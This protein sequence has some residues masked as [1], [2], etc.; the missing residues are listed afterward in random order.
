MFAKDKK[1]NVESKESLGSQLHS[2]ID[3]SDMFKYENIRE[4]MQNLNENHPM[5]KARINKSVI[6]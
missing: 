2:E 3:E 4:K 1:N 5:L 6:K